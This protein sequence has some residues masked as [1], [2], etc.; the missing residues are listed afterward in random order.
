MQLEI[1]MSSLS[2]NAS[3]TAGSSGAVYTGSSIRYEESEIWI[4]KMHVL[5][6]HY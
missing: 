2:A 4:L 5:E 3:A 6:L 1:S